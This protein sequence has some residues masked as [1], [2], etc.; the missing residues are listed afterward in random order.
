MFQFIKE[1]IDTYLADFYDNNSCEMPD[2][3]SQEKAIEFYDS[4]MDVIKELESEMDNSEPFSFPQIEKKPRPKTDEE[5]RNEYL[6][7]ARDWC[8]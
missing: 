6:T 5:I 8:G 2:E 1:R 3:V 7:E 4:L